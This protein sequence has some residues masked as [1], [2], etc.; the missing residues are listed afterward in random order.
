MEDP[1][2]TKLMATMEDVVWK[3][4]NVV[5]FLLVEVGDMLQVIF[6]G[7]ISKSTTN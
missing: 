4:E 3:L 1:M 2:P 7:G 6:V 5:V